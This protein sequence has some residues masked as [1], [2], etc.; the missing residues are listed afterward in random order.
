M[1]RKVV[2]AFCGFIG[3]VFA[4]NGSGIITV[5][6]FTL[7]IIL[8]L[9]SSRHL[10]LGTIITA[11]FLE[12]TWLMRERIHFCPEM[13]YDTPVRI[14]ISH[15]IKPLVEEIVVEAELDL[16]HIVDLHLSNF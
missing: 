15:G 6:V 3:G 8:L 4:W 2:A 11:G 9:I 1:G 10:I 7:N 16:V 5:V 13:L 12:F 14:S